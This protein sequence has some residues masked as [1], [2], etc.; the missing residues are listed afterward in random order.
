[1]LKNNIKLSE[2]LCT[3]REHKGKLEEDLNQ[4]NSILEDVFNDSPKDLED[5]GIAT[6]SVKAD[7]SLKEK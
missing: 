3:T 2:K 1:M 4:S 6:K 5:I 7:T